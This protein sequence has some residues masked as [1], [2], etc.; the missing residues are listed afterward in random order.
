MVRCRVA[1]LAVVPVVA[2]AVVPVASAQ[3]PVG[4]VPA[5]DRLVV[6]EPPP[7]VGGDGVE[8]MIDGVDQGRQEDVIVGHREAPQMKLG[9]LPQRKSFTPQRPNDDGGGNDG[10]SGDS[11]GP[12]GDPVDDSGSS[13]D[14]DEAAD[15]ADEALNG[16][17]YSTDNKTIQEKVESTV[18][19]EGKPYV[20]ALDWFAAQMD[21]AGYTW[22][23][24]KKKGGSGDCSGFMGQLTAIVYG[25]DPWVRLF[26]TADE[27]AVAKKLG[28]E[29]RPGGGDL[30]LGEFAIGWYNGGQGGG[31]TAGTL[32]SGVNV[33]SGGSSSS[34]SG[35]GKSINM[36]GRKAVPANHSSFVE[37]MAV[38]PW[39]YFQENKDRL[40]FGK[41]S[42]DN[43]DW[44][45]TGSGSENPDMA[46]EKAKGDC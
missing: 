44:R 38:V 24:P 10:S 30:K 12:G 22:G 40:A 1:W 4:W 6:A 5:P 21:G 2:S 37:G 11:F 23:G 31:H 29:I 46:E 7:Q 18:S 28:M 9:D 13:V 20:T 41:V 42:W 33:E 32:P 36:Y 8:G 3:E 15:S 43:E 39:S 19:E 27:G 25:K 17:G 45:C 14:Q 35:T 34:I 16:E 26:S